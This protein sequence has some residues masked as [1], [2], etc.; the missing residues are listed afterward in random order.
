MV[1]IYWSV[2]GLPSECGSPPLISGHPWSVELLTHFNCSHTFHVTCLPHHLQ[3]LGIRPTQTNIK[4][5]EK[6]CSKWDIM[7][8]VWLSGI[9]NWAN[10]WDL[11]YGEPNDTFHIIHVKA[12]KQ[13]FL[14]GISDL[15]KCSDL[16]LY[17]NY[18]QNKPSL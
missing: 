8:D 3:S 18:M 10:A 15:W 17:R 7:E 4:F 2:T 6:H 5:D 1:A 9:I 12:Q 16:T 14:V 13:I 11:H